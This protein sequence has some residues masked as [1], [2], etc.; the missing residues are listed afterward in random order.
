MKIQTLFIVKLWD[1]CAKQWSIVTEPDT[2]D[3]AKKSLE[4]ITKNG[5]IL[6]KPSRGDYFKIFPVNKSNIKVKQI[7][8]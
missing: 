2:Y 8:K 5:T 1:N 3:G 4:K 6:C 7:K